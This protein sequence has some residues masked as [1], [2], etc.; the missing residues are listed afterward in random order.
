MAKAIRVI[1]HPRQQQLHG[2]VRVRSAGLPGFDPATE[3]TAGKRT[4][5]TV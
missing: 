2:F 4:Q 1:I 5:F 3:Q